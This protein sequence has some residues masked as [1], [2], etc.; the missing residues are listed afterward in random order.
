MAESVVINLVNNGEVSAGDFVVRAGGVALTASGRKAVLAANER[1]LS[2][3]IRHP[4]FGYKVSYR[5][6][7]E[8][9]VRLLGALPSITAMTASCSS[10]SENP[11][12]RTAHESSTS[13][14]L[15]FFQRTA[16]PSSDS[17]ERS[18][19]PPNPGQRSNPGQH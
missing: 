8:V 5:R 12:D 17:S 10:T 13:E 6:V 2:T 11:A 19:D 15:P 18:K 16:Q 7:L 14:R 3:T 9:Q 1:R 4:T